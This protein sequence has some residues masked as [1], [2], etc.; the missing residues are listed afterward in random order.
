VSSAFHQAASCELSLQLSR[1]PGAVIQFDNRPCEGSF[2]SI[3][4]PASR[5]PGSV[6][7]H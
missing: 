6:L 3:A 5:S 7:V 1:L 2:L 4:V